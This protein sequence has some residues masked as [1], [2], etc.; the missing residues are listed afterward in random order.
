MAAR[1]EANLA[2]LRLRLRAFGRPMTVLRDKRSKARADLVIVAA[3]HERAR[4]TL[5]RFGRPSAV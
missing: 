1:R 4:S 2:I 3:P 5:S